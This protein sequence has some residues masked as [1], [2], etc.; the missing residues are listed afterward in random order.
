MKERNLCQK[1]GINELLD[2]NEIETG[3]CK[4]CMINLMNNGVYCD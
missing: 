3:I 1:C 4:E 2:D